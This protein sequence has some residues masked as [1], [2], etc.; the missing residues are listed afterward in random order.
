[1]DISMTLGSSPT[2][3]ICKDFSATQAA[4]TAL[5]H[6][7]TTDPL[8]ALSAYTDH[9]SQHGL[10]SPWLPEVTTAEDITKA[11]GSSTGC[12]HPHES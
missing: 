5:G 2:T 8:M 11:S 9:K 6:I 7:R 4:D 12:L 10:T 3:D 1:M